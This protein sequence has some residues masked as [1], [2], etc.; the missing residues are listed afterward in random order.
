MFE[1][2]AVQFTDRTVRAAAG[3]L[4]LNVPAV[5]FVVSQ[6][7]PKFQQQIILVIITTFNFDEKSINKTI[8]LNM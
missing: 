4:T 3:G 5:F 7:L 8:S 2:A 1:P 6:I